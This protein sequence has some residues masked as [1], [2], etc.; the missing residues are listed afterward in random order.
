MPNFRTMA[1]RYVP[2]VAGKD[3]EQ[4]LNYTDARGIPLRWFYESF[5]YPAVFYKKGSRPRLEKFLARNK[6][7]GKPGLATLEKC[8]SALV[9]QM[10]HYVQLDYEG[11]GNRG[12]SEE[13]LLFSGH[14][15]CNEQARVLVA[16]TQV[17]RMPSRLVFGSM[18]IK[19]GHVVMEVFVD[20]KWVLV[21]QTANF[22]FKRK[23]GK[24]VN[25]LDIKTDKLVAAEMNR[26]YQAALD[27]G[28][29]AAVRP[30]LWDK[31]VPWGFS[32]QPCE[33]FWQVG[34]CNYFIH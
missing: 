28:R 4:S 16:L 14:G 8:V 18:R 5:T 32:G 1:D 17:L 6:V 12:A 25:V 33:L 26:L 7:T 19:K 3:L 2:P 30:D 20:G 9:R 13:E 23:N 24:P 27:K 11:A 31:Y 34:Y 29:A 10:P 21:D 22:V 15:W